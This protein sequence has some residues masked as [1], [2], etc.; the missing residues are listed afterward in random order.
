[1][2]PKTI[3]WQL[4]DTPCIGKVAVFID[5]R[6][7]VTLWRQIV[8]RNTQG[9]T[10]ATS[11]DCDYAALLGT[12]ASDIKQVF[13]GYFCWILSYSNLLAASEDFLPPF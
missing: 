3:F 2:T 1:M 11:W 13:A 9:E 5:P 10:P 7:T 12:L 8:F 6:A 4:D